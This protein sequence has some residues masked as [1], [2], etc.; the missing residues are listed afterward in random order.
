MME[1]AKVVEVV[2]AAG[3]SETALLKLPSFS[4]REVV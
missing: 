2:E 4:T 1:T 3:G